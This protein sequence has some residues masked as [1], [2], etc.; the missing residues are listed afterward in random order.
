MIIEDRPGYGRRTFT[1][2]EAWTASG[3]MTLSRIA[4]FFD[5]ATD[6]FRDD[7]HLGAAYSREHR[8]Q[9][10]VADSHIRFVS[11]IKAGDTIRTE[12][13]LVAMARNRLHLLHEIHKEDQAIPAT[14]GEMLIIHVDMDTRRACPIPDERIVS[15]Q[16][17]LDEQRGEVLTSSP[18]M[19]VSVQR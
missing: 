4:T 18:G 6:T 7:M 5:E 11:E 8:R 13:R 19:R 9:M 15:L 10:F 1:V 2:P 12:T 14:I 17:L 3:H 16:A